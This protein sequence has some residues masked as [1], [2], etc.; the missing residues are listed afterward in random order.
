MIQLRDVKKVFNQGR[1]NEIWAVRGV[2][3]DLEPSRRI[4]ELLGRPDKQLDSVIIAGTNGKGST[5][6]FLTGIAKAAGNV[7]QFNHPGLSLSCQAVAG[8]G[9]RLAAS[10]VSRASASSASAMVGSAPSNTR[11]IA[12]CPKP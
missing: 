9:L 1:G 4:L 11:S 5:C 10:M 7:F 2:T 6:A 12:A 8:V 3:L